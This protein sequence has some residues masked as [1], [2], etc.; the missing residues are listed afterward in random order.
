[1]IAQC[2][3]KSFSFFVLFIIRRCDSDSG[4]V[5]GSDADRCPD[6]YMLLLPHSRLRVGFLVLAEAQR[7]PLRGSA[8]ATSAA[9]PSD[10]EFRVAGGFQQQVDQSRFECPAKKPERQERQLVGGKQADA[11]S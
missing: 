3:K 6:R 9:E 5:L 11:E 10:G 4:G 1:M 7:R 2:K 8:R